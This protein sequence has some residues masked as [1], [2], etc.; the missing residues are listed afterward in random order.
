MIFFSSILSKLGICSAEAAETEAPAAPAWVN[1]KTPAFKDNC[2][3]L[4]CIRH[5]N[6]V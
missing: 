2:Q 6:I 5:P 1:T 4:R 3:L